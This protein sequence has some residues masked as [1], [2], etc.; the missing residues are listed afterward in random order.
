MKYNK[1]DDNI[2]TELIHSRRQINKIH[3][4]LIDKMRMRRKQL[5]KL[6][7]EKKL[8]ENRI[9]SLNYMRYA[10]GK[11]VEIQDYQTEEAIINELKQIEEFLLLIDNEYLNSIGPTAEEILYWE[12]LSNLH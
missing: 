2:D 9:I 1:I 4:K 5:L 11:D 8:H 12:N 10:D 7:Q 3:P 6:Q